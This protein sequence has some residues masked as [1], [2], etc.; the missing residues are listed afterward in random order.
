V[1]EILPSLDIFVL[2][3]SEEALGTSILEA[4][5]CGV[6]V[7]AS[8]IGGIP[9]C[10]ED[11]K[12]GFLFEAENVDKLKEKLKILI[13]NENLRKSF[14]EYGRKMVKEKFSVKKMLE[15]TKRLYE[16]LI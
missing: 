6:S 16:E 1:A 15:D 4:S 10:V 14:G 13:E 11:W 2:P 9:E 5:S 8:K 12:S 7:V 3:S